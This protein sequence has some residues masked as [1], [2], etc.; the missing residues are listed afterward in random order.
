M[1]LIF[2]ES[3]NPNIGWS[4]NFSV[5]LPS[6]W[7]TTII[8]AFFLIIVLWRWEL[9]WGTPPVMAEMLGN[10]PLVAFLLSLLVLTAAVSKGDFPLGDYS[11]SHLPLDMFIQ[12]IPLDQLFNIIFKLDSISIFMVVALVEAVVIWFIRSICFFNRAK[13][14]NSS[15]LKLSIYTVLV[16]FHIGDLLGRYLS[17]L[18]NIPRLESYRHR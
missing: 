5:V 15:F 1:P 2:S 16:N 18:P 17:Y 12:P 11:L 9:A 7:W 14:S 4:K 10:F 3:R 13:R 6:L 8:S